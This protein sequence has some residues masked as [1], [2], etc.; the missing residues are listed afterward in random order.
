MAK[1][2][3]FHFLFRVKRMS[4]PSSLPKYAFKNSFSE[5]KIVK[6]LIGK[7][8]KKG[9]KIPRKNL[10]NIRTQGRRKRVKG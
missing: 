1:W 4:S 10:I 6:E 7:Y 8:R 5:V 9:F 3:L 2:P